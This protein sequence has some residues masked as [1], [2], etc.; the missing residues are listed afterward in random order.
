MMAKPGRLD[1]LNVA[2]VPLREVSGLALRRGGSEMLA[3]GDHDPIV[4]VASTQAWPPTWRGI[5]LTHLDLPEGGTQFEAVV[6]VG[7]DTVLILQEEPARVLHVDLAQVSLLGELVLEVPEGHELREAWLADRSSRGESL[8]LLADGHLLVVKEKDPTALLE[9]GP[10]G[11]AA[12]GWTAG[13]L[14]TPPAPGRER[15]TAIATWWLDDAAGHHLED[16]SD[17]TIGPDGRLYL[18]SD[19]S[20][21]IARLPAVL[22][23]SDRTIA[24]DGVWR[25]AGAPENAEGLVLLDDGTPLVAIDTKKGERNLLR[26][27]RL[28]LV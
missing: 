28:P 11:A 7:D 5:D 2:D 8:V 10:A 26:L 25:I 4:L 15:M 14:V 12:L 27:E 20:S 19:K 22:P 17:A 24:L 21:S 18:L 6:P 13:A 3:V 16:V 9:M 23:P 1:V